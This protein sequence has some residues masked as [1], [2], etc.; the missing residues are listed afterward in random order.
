MEKGFTLTE[1]IILFVIFITVA[2]LVVPLSVD[3]AITKNSTSK[4]KRVQS[5]L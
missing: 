1:V 3:D 4:W 2:I 5:S